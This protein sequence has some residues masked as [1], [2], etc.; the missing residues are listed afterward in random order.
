MPRSSSAGPIRLAI[1]G[2]EARPIWHIEQFNDESSDQ[3]LLWCS[4]C[5]IRRA[6]TY[7]RRSRK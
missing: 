6:K 2:V 4:R 3:S 7:A 5:C 1:Q